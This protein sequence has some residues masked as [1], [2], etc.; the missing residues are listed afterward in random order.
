MIY[1]LSLII[2]ENMMVYPGDPEV[3][4]T[5]AS[6]DGEPEVRALSLGTHTATH[7][8]APSHVIPG[9]ETIDEIPLS[10]FC[11]TAAV[12]LPDAVDIPDVEIVLVSLGGERLWGGR[13]YYEEYPVMGA[14]LAERILA[15]P[16]IKAVGVDAPSIDRDLE[17]HRLFLGRGI[18]VYESLRGLSPLAGRQGR[19]CGMPLAISGGDG[20]PVRAVFVG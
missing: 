10:H 8:D 4:I 3:E 1:D 16:S 20:S 19:F 2:E 13:R 6:K 12:I 15:L 17:L 7:V 5:L 18:V 14:D 11:G 9:G